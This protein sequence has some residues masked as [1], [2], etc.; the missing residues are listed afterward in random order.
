MM[1]SLPFVRGALALLIFDFVS[2]T[3]C[4][5]YNKT[6]LRKELRIGLMLANQPLTA[7]PN[8][9][10][11]NYPFFLQLVRPAIQI[12]VETVKETILP[13]HHISITA[14]DTKCEVDRSQILV[15]D[16]Y[17]KYHVDVLF[18]PACEFAGAP[19]LRFADHWNMPMLTVG[20]RSSGLDTYTS[21]TRVIGSYSR[22]GE[23][24]VDMVEYFEW[25]DTVLFLV[26]EY[27]GPYNDYSLACSPPYNQ[28][29][30]KKYTSPVV[31]FDSYEKQ[32]FTEELQKIKSSGRGEYVT[33]FI[34]PPVFHKTLLASDPPFL[35]IYVRSTHWKG[36]TRCGHHTPGFARIRKL[37]ER[38]FWACF[39]I[40]RFVFFC[41][42]GCNC[43]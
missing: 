11:P 14:G 21:L 16:M 30:A 4:M 41:R 35:F 38:S 31:T 12:G 39:Q 42:D 37:G 29:L 43:E 8:E 32:N 7:R 33:M 28:L 27:Y 18:G 2:L 5:F 13:D 3:E 6:D 34:C 36:P 40:H 17:A 23:M 10:A 24:I 26:Y 15:V 22:L 1:I 20:C 25:R 19:P 9:S